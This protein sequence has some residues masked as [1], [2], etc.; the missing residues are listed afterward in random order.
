M[1]GDEAE[2]RCLQWAKRQHGV[3]RREQALAAGLTHGQIERKLRS[4]RW[5][6]I[7][8]G[9]YR[10]TGSSSDG[11]QRRSLPAPWPGSLRPCWGGE[12]ADSRDIEVA[13]APRGCRK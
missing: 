1:G 12:V 8:P 10:V 11:R 5:Q 7:H 2:P 6:V 9:V 13:L 4:Q 3:V